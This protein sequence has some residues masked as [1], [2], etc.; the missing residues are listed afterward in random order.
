[1]NKWINIYFILFLFQS[2]D[3]V[4]LFSKKLNKRK[5]LE[6]LNIFVLFYKYFVT[7]IWHEL[8]N[9]SRRCD[10]LNVELYIMEFWTPAKIPFRSALLATP[11][12]NSVSTELRKKYCLNCTLKRVSWKPNCCCPF[13]KGESICADRPALSPCSLPR[14][15]C[16]IYWPCLYRKRWSSSSLQADSRWRQPSAIRV[17]AGPATSPT[18][19]AV[20]IDRM[21]NR[22]EVEL[23]NFVRNK[24]CVNTFY[25]TSIRRKDR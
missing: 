9:I 14:S 21:R 2:V 19:S 5:N 4:S 20:F 23:R 15:W 12:I 8:R 13:K 16:T 10:A 17:V 6:W 24:I 1:M 7:R 18:G 25:G 3:Y 22:P 11:I